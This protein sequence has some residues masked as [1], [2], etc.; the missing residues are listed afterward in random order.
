MSKAEKID[1]IKSLLD[2]V[3]TI[4]VTSTIPEK[5]TA[6]SIAKDL[7]QSYNMPKNPTYDEVNINNAKVMLNVVVATYPDKVAFFVCQSLE[8]ALSELLK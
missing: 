7:I 5:L 1:L 6:L 8:L 2:E 3:G 4:H